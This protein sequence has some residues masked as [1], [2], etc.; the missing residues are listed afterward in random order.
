[1]T[2]EQTTDR[3]AAIGAVEEAN[4]AIGAS[5]STGE[6]QTANRALLSAVQTALAD[7]AAVLDGRQDLVMVVDQHRHDLER[8]L[9]LRTHGRHLPAPTR[10]S[11]AA[12][13]SLAAGLLRLARTVTQRAA[14]S[15]EATDSDG[16]ATLTDYLTALPPLLDLLAAE[17][18]DAE[19][20][21]VPV[22]SCIEL[23]TSRAASAPSSQAG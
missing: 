21:S 5:L 22:G 20:R 17:L 13:H 1:M 15:V 12:R 4:A 10:R 14:R 3:A 18:D 19:E 8:A 6:P 16:T 9:T 7:V 2:I 23:A 11:L